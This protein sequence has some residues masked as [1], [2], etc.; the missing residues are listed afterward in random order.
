MERHMRNH[1]NGSLI[2]FND[3]FVQLKAEIFRRISYYQSAEIRPHLIVFIDNENAVFTVL[4]VVVS[5]F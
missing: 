3:L 4:W 1:E 5:A 2:S